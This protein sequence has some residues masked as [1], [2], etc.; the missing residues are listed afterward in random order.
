[1]CIEKEI[2]FGLL[3][4]ATAIL[5]VMEMYF[6]AHLAINTMNKHIKEADV[7]IEEMR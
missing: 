1:M 5:Y 3:L 4:E 6:G 2:S 7:Y